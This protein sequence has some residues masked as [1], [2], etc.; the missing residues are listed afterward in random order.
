[1]LLY[2]RYLFDQLI[3]YYWLI[4]NYDYHTWTS[5]PLPVFLNRLTCEAYWSVELLNM[6]DLLQLAVATGGICLVVTVTSCDIPHE[7]SRFWFIRLGLVCD[8]RDLSEGPEAARK[9]F[10]VGMF[11]VPFASF[12]ANHLNLFSEEP[13]GVALLLSQQEIPLWTV[14]DS[15]SWYILMLLEVCLKSKT[16]WK[17]EQPSHQMWDSLRSARNMESGK[18]QTAD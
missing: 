4:T 12:C 15:W 11:V 2:F 1:M 14:C 17:Y 3:C 13:D 5:V 16:W 6:L 9:S 7:T 18:A 10:G 8:A